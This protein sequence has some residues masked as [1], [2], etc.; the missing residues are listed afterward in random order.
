[1]PKCPKCHK[2]IDHLNAVVDERQVYSYFGDGSGY[3][4]VDQIEFN[5]DIYRC[6][7]CYQELDIEDAD[8][9]LAS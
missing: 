6:P 3:H 5:V 2:E 1:M 7:E 8:E 9:F 4:H